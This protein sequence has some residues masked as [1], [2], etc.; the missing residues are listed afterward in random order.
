MHHV[1]LVMRKH[2]VEEGGKGGNQTRPQGVGKE[3]D[4]RDNPVKGGMGRGLDHR[5][6]ALVEAGGER[7]ADLLQGF[8]IEYEQLVDGG[9]GCWRRAGR[10]RRF[11]PLLLFCWRHGNGKGG[12]L[13]MH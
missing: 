5:P 8:Q 7:G 9:S 4:L 10:R 6:P 1:D 11:L 3:S 13:K 2:H 12:E